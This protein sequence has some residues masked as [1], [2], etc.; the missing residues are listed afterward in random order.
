M[1]AV[2]DTSVA[3]KGTAVL[4]DASVTVVTIWRGIDPAVFDTGIGSTTT[5]TP[6][7]VSS[8]T[9]GDLWVQIYSNNANS[10]PTAAPTSPVGYT[11]QATQGATDTNSIGLGVATRI[12]A[13]V[14]SEA[15]NAWTGGTG[16]SK[17]T[18]SFGLKPA[19][20]AGPLPLAVK[21]IQIGVLVAAERAANW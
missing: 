11:L 18:M 17:K 16:A 13:S 8:V 19:V 3:M 1:G 21:P 6:Q 20:A 15:P 2:P 4:T 5:A 12:Q 9:A 14:G 10:V 7:A